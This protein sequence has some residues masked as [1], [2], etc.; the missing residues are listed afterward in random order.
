MSRSKTGSPPSYRLHKPRNCAVV[1]IDGRDYYLGPYGSP[2]SKQKYAGLIR[3]WEQRKE[4]LGVPVEAPLD[5][6]DRPTVDEVILVYL[7]HVAIYY[8]PNNGENT[9]AGCID[10]ALKVVQEC[11]FGSEFAD[12]FRPKDLKLV[13]DAMIKRGWSRGYINS[14]INRVKRMFRHAVEEDLIPGTVYHALIAVNGLRRGT[15]GVVERGKVRPVPREDIKAALRKSHHVLK[16]MLLFAYYTGARPG[17][18]CALKPCHLNRE[19]KVWVYHVPPDANKTEHHEQDRKVFIGPRA[20]KIL[21]RWLAG[22]QPDD[23][24]FSPARAEALR[25]AARRKRRKTPL[26]PSHM[27]RLAAKK[28]LAP[29]RARRDHYDTASFRR[30]VKRAC[31]AGGVPAWSPNR[32]RHNAATRFR[33]KFGLETARILLGHRKMNTTEI[34]A[35]ADFSKARQAAGRLG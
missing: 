31:R 24:V 11:G 16:A 30:A 22:V 6:S 8:K 20:Q 10:D 21:R 27:A 26:W 19:K 2:S 25:L 7:K 35:E 13:R 29:K 9:E 12:S 14:Q 1:T 15:P 32:L 17:E 34:Y 18:I 28:K 3:A 23:Y 33:R 5:P 4:Q